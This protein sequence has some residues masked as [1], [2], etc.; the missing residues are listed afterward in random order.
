MG[1]ISRASTGRAVDEL[2]VRLA[3]A[4]EHAI[5][6]IVRRRGDAIKTAVEVV[7]L[8]HPDATP[9]DVARLLVYQAQ[10][11]VG[12]RRRRL[13]AAGSLPGRRHAPPRS[14][15]AWPTR[16]RSSTRRSRS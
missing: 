4:T 13:G 1:L 9:N 6:E 5:D 8:Q 15:R 7:R 2:A 10:Q 3:G 14:A 11:G 12:D 16:S